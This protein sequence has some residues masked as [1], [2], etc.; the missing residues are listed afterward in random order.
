MVGRLL[1]DTHPNKPLTKVDRMTDTPHRYGA[2]IDEWTWAEYQFG[3][4]I[5]PAVGNPFLIQRRSE[6]LQHLNSLAKTPSFIGS[7]GVCYGVSKWTAHIA[8]PETTRK[9]KTDPSLNVLLITRNVRAIDI[10]IADQDIADKFEH[11]ICSML[12]QRLPVRYRDGTG[13]RTM[14][15]RLDPHTIIR[16]RVVHTQWG[17]IEFLADGQQTAVFGT[18]PDG[19][20]FKHRGFETGIPT[21]GQSL[22][23]NVWD[24]L[25]KNFDPNAKPL[26]VE[27]EQLGE[28]VLRNGGALKDDPILQHLYDE[29]LVQAVEASGIVHVRCPN[30]AQHTSSSV[31]STSYFPPGLGNKQLPGFRCLHSHCE[32]ISTSIFLKLIGYEQKEISE[33]FGQNLEP[34]PIVLVQQKLEAMPVETKLDAREALV[35]M[36]GIGRQ[37][38]PALDLELTAKGNAYTKT[39]SNL[40]RVLSCPQIV[41]MQ[42][43]K[44]KMT[45]HVRLGGRGAYEKMSDDVVSRVRFAVEGILRVTY[46]HE[47]ISRQMAMIGGFD[48]FDSAQ[49]WLSQQQWDGV[50][51]LKHFA[52]DI[53]KA[54]AGEYGEVLGEYL[55]CALAGRILS[56][57]AKCD[58][59]PVLV[60]QKQGTGKSTLVSE[61]PPFADWFGTADFTVQD[62]DIYRSIRGKNVLELPELRGLTGRDAAGTKALLTQSVDSWTPKYLEHSIDVPRRC[63]FIGTDNRNRFLTDPTG[64]RRFAPIKVARTAE[65]IDWPAYIEHR[66]QYYAEA[67]AILAKHR[68]PDAG[69]ENFASKLRKLA[70]P[71]VAD[72]TVLDPWYPAVRDFVYMQRPGTHISLVAVHNALFNSGVGAID[73][74]KAWRIRG[75]MTTLKLEEVDGDVWQAPT[76]FVL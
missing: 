6:R 36:V 24:E 17:A 34:H 1:P 70:A 3:Q 11:Q 75:I 59:M 58:I 38:A 16:K 48:E 30:E 56:P 53:L 20:R 21:V 29:G 40:V 28:Y 2:T 26:I 4:D 62:D 52:A 42:I 5:L 35:E 39:I 32:H 18:H 12:G 13:K 45:T 65:F 27:G 76:G 46:S 72:A 7:N 74:G 8:T 25:R 15:L 61:L 19:S 67:A 44:F 66:N 37:M 50:E 33:T 54:N 9:W 57:G 73:T 51:R 22:M 43:D 23:A 69:I 64:N 55:F 47:E 10:D 68:T 71:Y 49:Q 60:S 14:L 31:G 63:L 41:D